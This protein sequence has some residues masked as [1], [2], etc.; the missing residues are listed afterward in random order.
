MGVDNIA[1]E[2]L[3][4]PAL[5]NCLHE[6]YSSCFELHIVPRMWYR[7]II[8]PILKKGKS[9]L[10]PLSHRGISLMSCVCKVFSAILNTRLVLF[11]EVSDIFADEQNGFRRLRS[12]VDYLFVLTTI[13]RNRKQKGLPTFCCFV[14]FEKA[15]DS[16]S[17]P[18][19]WHKLLAY[20][21]HG[22]MLNTV[23]SL[24]S[25]LESC[26]RV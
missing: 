8:H 23:K 16:V 3:K 19:L 25:N 9:P 13:L 5:Q 7:A 11:A 6:L 26:V 22:H 21:V 2:I 4:V 1:N 15:F 14:D 20:G 18:A 12:C 24:Y 17:Y 10:F